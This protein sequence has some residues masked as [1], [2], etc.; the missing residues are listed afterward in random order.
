MDNGYM[1]IMMELLAEFSTTVQSCTC[2]M[3]DSFTPCI[4]VASRTTMFQG[5]SH[6]S[7][8]FKYGTI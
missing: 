1:S 5:S 4:S 8:S 6:F 7:V 2:L 3:L